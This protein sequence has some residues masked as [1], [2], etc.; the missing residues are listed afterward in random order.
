MEELNKKME[1]F[2]VEFSQ[3]IDFMT[4]EDFNKSVC[5][6]FYASVQLYGIIVFFSSSAV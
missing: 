2:L 4:E 1:E 3:K 5:S 6:Q